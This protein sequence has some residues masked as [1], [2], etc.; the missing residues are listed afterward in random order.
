MCVCVC[1][2]VLFFVF[3]SKWIEVLTGVPQR[4]ITGSF[5]FLIYINDNIGGCVRLFADDTSLCYI[6]DIPSKQQVVLSPCFA[7][8]Y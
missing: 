3:G 4:S 1:V 2:C 8:Q 7:V 6:V 5:L